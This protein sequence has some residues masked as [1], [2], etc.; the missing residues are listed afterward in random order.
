MES[1]NNNGAGLLSLFLYTMQEYD[2]IVSSVP[3][4][5]RD[6]L[7]SDVVHCTSRDYGF[8]YEEVSWAAVSIR[9]M[10]QRKYYSN[11]ESVQLKRLLAIAERDQRFDGAKVAEIRRRLKSLKHRE[12]ELSLP[13]GEVVSG[14]FKNIEDVVYGGLLHADYDKAL[15]LRSFPK[16]VRFYA[17]AP[18]VIERER[19]IVDF[20]ELCLSSGVCEIGTIEGD[21]A[22]IAGLDVLRGEDRLIAKSPYWA[23]V[24][25]HDAMD[26]EIEKTVDALSEDDKNA[27][28]VAMDF[29]EMLKSEPLDLKALRSVVW[30]DYW[31]DWGDFGQASEMI[32]SIPAPGASTHVMH[33]GGAEYAQVKILPKVLH[34]WVTNTP[35][36]LT[37]MYLVLLTK[38]FGM[39]KVNGIMNSCVE[40]GEVE[41]QS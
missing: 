9:M 23:N 1:S 32:K 41:R 34:A 15:R 40:N 7:C 14:H 26:E 25:G 39:W 17:L 30:R 20:K 6:D 36:V 38:R 16:D 21:R 3:L 18:F 13:N 11:G 29:V 35:Q 12:V 28:L 10:L 2:G 5:T 8:E 37:G 22:P 24:A 27:L 4:R 19:L 33:E 31:A